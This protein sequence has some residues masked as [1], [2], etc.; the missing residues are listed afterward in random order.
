V[1]AKKLGGIRHLFGAPPP[2]PSPAHAAEGGESADSGA[3]RTDRQSPPLSVSAFA[4]IL[5]STIMTALPGTFRITGEISNFTSR[6]HFYF[7]I[8]DDACVINAVMWASRAKQVRFAPAAGQQ[9]IITGSVQYYKPRGTLQLIVDQLEAVGAGSLDEQLRSLIA[10]VRAL[11]WLDDDR[12]R[13]LPMLPRTVAVITSRTGAALADVRTTMQQRCPAVGIALIDTLVQ[14]DG[15][16][17]AITAAIRAISAAAGRLGID[18]ILL[19][20][21]GGSMEDLWAFNSREVAQA[22]VECSVPVVAAIGHETDTTLAELVADARAST[23]TQAAMRLTPDRD[24][25][26]EQLDTTIVR[27]GMLC[28]RLLAAASAQHNAL[29]AR[30]P[31]AARSHLAQRRGT[32][33][34]LGERLD[35][36]RPAK[37]LSLRTSQLQAISHR[38]ES[39]RRE[40][41]AGYRRAAMERD[42]RLTAAMTALLA[43]ARQRALVSERQL[44]LVGP[45]SVLR[46]G[47]SITLGPDGRVLTDSAQV[48]SGS[49]LTTQL[50]EGTVRSVVTDDSLAADAPAQQRPQGS[51]H[52]PRAKPADQRGDQ[53]RDQSR[54]LFE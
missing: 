42:A 14:G 43:S 52:A 41:M 21:G 19:T 27:L 16:V 11:G 32:L 39:A 8:K 22:I 24:A 4:E 25:L 46:R 51:R 10:E 44:D 2:L 50:A 47:F 1:P 36:A 13:L 3:A 45:G 6:T 35:R 33:A 12:K 26:A 54:G 5:D 38:F 48:T 29:A 18:A 34:A 9:V 31:H 30:V 37:Q 23:P 17:R 49:T 7:S 28:R 20:R 53:S 15:A 40:L